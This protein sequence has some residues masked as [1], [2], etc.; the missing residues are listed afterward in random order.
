MIKYRVGNLIDAAM[1]DDLNVIAHCCNCFN[2]MKSGIAPKIATAFPGAFDVDQATVRGAKNKLG[3]MTY[4]Y[5][6]TY[7]T[8][9]FNLYG[10]Y[11]FWKRRKGEM[12]LD[13]EAL[14]SSLHKM[15]AL[16][17][18]RCRILDMEC[19]E[20]KVGLP[21]IG[22]GLAGGDWSIISE[23]VERHLG[24]FDTTIYV[25]KESDLD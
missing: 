20:F 7:N 2:A 18:S 11:G 1:S 5:D 10:Q 13:Y 15:S 25:L 9:V 22:A 21:K 24:W 19:S 14:N 17:H 12:D 23:M 16:L 6:L 3:D 4:S 8:L